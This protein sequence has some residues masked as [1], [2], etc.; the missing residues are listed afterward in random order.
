MQG[1]EIGVHK[2]SF[3]SHEGEAV[4]E[5]IVEDPSMKPGSEGLMVYLNGGS[6]LNEV[7]GKVEAAGV[8]LKG[9]RTLVNVTVDAA[10]NAKRATVTTSAEIIEFN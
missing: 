9:S 5:A 7:L 4:G 8:E 1:A 3:F 6:D 10:A 2:M